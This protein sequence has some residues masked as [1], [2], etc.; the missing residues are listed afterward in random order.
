V[1][2]FQ[3]SLEHIQL[4]SELRVPLGKDLERFRAHNAGK[5]ATLETWGGRFKE[6]LQNG[7]E[8]RKKNGTLLENPLIAVA[9]E[10]ALFIAK[11]KGGNIW[12]RKCSACLEV[13]R[14]N[15]NHSR[16]RKNASA[17]THVR[18]R[19]QHE[20]RRHLGRLRAV[21]TKIDS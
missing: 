15:P 1:E 4:A 13:L 9:K 17:I 14:V 7:H 16:H 18:T 20:P 5:R 19:G 6:W 12:C 2:D 8:Y 11:A 3:P 21:R 10:H